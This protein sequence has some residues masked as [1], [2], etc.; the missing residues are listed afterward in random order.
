LALALCRQFFTGEN[1]ML[2]ISDCEEKNMRSRIIL[3]TCPHVDFIAKSKGSVHTIRK[4]LLN[5]K[6]EI[7]LTHYLLS[8]IT[9][10]LI[11]FYNQLAISITIED[12]FDF[13]TRKSGQFYSELIASGPENSIDD[14]FDLLV[15]ALSYLTN[16]T[17]D[18]MDI[19]DYTPEMDLFSE[20]E[21]A[22][23]DSCIEKFIANHSGSKIS[24]PFECHFGYS[25]SNIIYFAGRIRKT[26]LHQI[27]LTQTQAIME[28]HGFDDNCKEIKGTIVEGDSAG[29]KIVLHTI[30][31]DIFIQAAQGYINGTKFSCLYKEK[32]NKSGGKAVNELLAFSALNIDN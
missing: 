32:D 28:I 15:N 25:G 31:H 13:H 27:N 16:M 1:A 7:K 9:E 19:F 22:F 26:V 10:Y 29:R 23:F 3:S 30:S 12:Q 8:S 18:Y 6:D 21:I 11:R 24:T 5:N 20:E 2:N 14:Y 17:I 4:K